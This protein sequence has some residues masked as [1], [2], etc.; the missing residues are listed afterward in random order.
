M[1]CG[2]SSRGRLPVGLRKTLEEVS[3]K[4]GNIFATLAQGR[5]V[6]GDDVEAVEEVLAEIAALDLLFE[7]LVGG[8]D[9][10]D[11]HRMDSWAPTGSKRCSSRDAQDFGLGPEAH[12]ADFVE[13]ER[14]AVGLLE[15]AD[16][17]LM[18]AG[19]AAFAVAEE[20]ALDQVFGDG[21]AV[22]FDEGLGGAGAHGM[23]GVRDEFLAGAAFAVD[24]HAAV[25]GRH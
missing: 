18:G 7:I 12:V 19:E 9:D 5:H 2:A 24:E 21:G 15:L 10:A 8:G 1:A 3:G 20:F 22:D 6:E 14:A 13:E 23:D 16:L 11:V 25:G 17:A 4:G